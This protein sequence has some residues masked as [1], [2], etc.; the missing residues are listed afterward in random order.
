MARSQGT[1]TY[2]LGRRGRSSFSSRFNGQDKVCPPTDGAKIREW[3]RG[4]ESPDE[5]VVPFAGH[6]IMIEAP[7]IVCDVMNEFLIKLEPQLSHGWQLSYTA[8]DKWSLKNEQKVAHLGT[9]TYRS[10]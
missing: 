9:L 3:L 4:T 1:S 2:Y 7:E 5:F 8:D 6:A 10:G